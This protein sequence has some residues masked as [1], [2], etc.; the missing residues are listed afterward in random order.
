MNNFEYHSHVM[1]NFP[2]SPQNMKLSLNQWFTV[3]TLFET[4]RMLKKIDIITGR[5]NNDFN[6]IDNILLDSILIV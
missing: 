4:E 3:L 5:I 2:Y 6:S 1:K